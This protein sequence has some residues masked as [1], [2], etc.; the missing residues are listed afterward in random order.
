MTLYI[1]SG[2]LA[3]G[4]LSGLP[5]DRPVDRQRSKIRPLEPPVDRPVDPEIP[6][7]E[8]SAAVDR[9]VDRTTVL[10]DM[11]KS[12]HVGRPWVDRPLVRSTARSTEL[13]CQPIPGLENWFKNLF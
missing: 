5:V 8:L 4:A 10:L 12:V 13:A 11:H 3:V 6:R 2:K 1:E 9:P 7:A